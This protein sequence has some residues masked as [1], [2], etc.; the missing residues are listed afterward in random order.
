[1][2]RVSCRALG[3]GPH[4]VYRPSL[5]GGS[6]GGWNMCSNRGTM[7]YITVCYLGPTL[8]SAGTNI[9]ILIHCYYCFFHCYYHHYHCHHHHHYYHYYY[10]SIDIPLTYYCI[11]Y[12]YRY[13]VIMVIIFSWYISLILGYQWIVLLLL[14]HD[15]TYMILLLNIVIIIIYHH[16]CSYYYY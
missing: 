3:K 5:Q 9:T 7:K 14:G 4:L 12:L 8:G 1:M 16:Y 10:A 15:H 2:K 11:L 6:N 13:I